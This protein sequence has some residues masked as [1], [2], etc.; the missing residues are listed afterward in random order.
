MRSLFLFAAIGSASLAQA[1][2]EL[3][4]ILQQYEPTNSVPLTTI[5]RWDPV[6][7][8]FLGSFGSGQLSSSGPIALDP[9]NPGSVT[10]FQLDNGTVQLQ[11]FNYS[12]GENLGLQTTAIN[13]TAVNDAKYTSSGNLLL[14]G[15][16]NGNVSARQYTLAGS[17]VR[18]YSLPLNTNSVIGINQGSDGTTYLLTRQPGTTSNNKFTVTSYASGSGV[19]SQTVVIADNTTNA[20]TGLTL[21]AGMLTIG[22]GS[23]A[24]RIG[25]SA[26][27]TTL[28]TPD[29]PSGG[30]LFA[31]DVMMNGHG[32][33]LHS[34]GYD[35][36]TS[37]TYFSTATVTNNSTG[38][39]TYLTDTRFG[40]IYDSAIVVAPEP[41]SLAAL[42]LGALAMTRR[43]RT[44]K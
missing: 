13:S 4:L 43:R 11:R 12:N 3:A 25:L 23:F 7:R 40:N 18:S 30:Y 44:G 31:S 35:S 22:G 37:R 15:L 16:I 27:G 8:T 19:I 1:S 41:A 39:Y 26:N 42:G 14:A 32:N 28:G 2:F 5:T 21:G 29:S 38:Q 20:R 36:T 10:N 17:L 34:M 24:A 9:T 6:T 33:S